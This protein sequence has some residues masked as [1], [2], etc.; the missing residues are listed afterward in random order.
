H[1]LGTWNVPGAPANGPAVSGMSPGRSTTAAATYT[2]NFT[3]TN[4]WQDLSVLNVL[5]NNAIDGRQGCYV[6]F[7]PTGANAG[8]VL[9]VNDLGDAGGPYAVLT[10]PGSAPSSVANSQCS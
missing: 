10:L 9:L 6:A 5:I 1:P 8:S 7:L 3:D 4:G 2:F